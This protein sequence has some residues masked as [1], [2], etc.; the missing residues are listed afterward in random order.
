MAESRKRWTKEEDNIL[1]QAI[2]ANPHNIK[3]ACKYVATK[4]E[5]RTSNACY[6]QWYKIKALAN[7]IQQ[8]N[9]LIIGTHNSMTFLRPAK[10][11]GWFMIPFARCQ[12]KTIM[13]QWKAGARVFD[14]RVKFDRYGNSYFAH[15]LYDCTY[16]LTLDFV[17][18]LIEQL[19][20]YYKEEVY[21]RLILEDTKAD[22]FQAEYFRDAC[23]R[24][25]EKFEHIHFFGGNRKGDWKKLYTFKRDVHDSLNNQW[26][27]SMMDDARWYEKFL[28]F[29]YALRCNK[30][31]KENVKPKF[32]L[33]DF[34]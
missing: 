31:N 10:W 18:R 15:G 22:N 25:E 5:G 6:K 16:L 7:S 2:K 23:K 17:I 27:S 4:L 34:I 3:E 13:Q 33:F 19:R 26:V 32:N 1:V 20:Y 21:V 14:L 11:Y 24:I 8:N 12:R 30:R 28:P 9:K 29:A